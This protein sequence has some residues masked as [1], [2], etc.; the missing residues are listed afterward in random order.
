[1]LSFVWQGSVGFFVILYIHRE[2]AGDHINVLLF[3]PPNLVPCTLRVDTK[4]MLSKNKE[5]P[6]KGLNEHS[7]LAAA[8]ELH[9]TMSTLT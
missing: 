3:F 8:G 7:K 9:L 5:V 6:V 4:Y 2:T 1:M